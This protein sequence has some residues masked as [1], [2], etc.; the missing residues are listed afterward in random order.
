[1]NI[2]LRKL[3]WRFAQIVLFLIPRIADAQVVINEL[4]QD[5]RTNAFSNIADT[6]EFIEL[7]NTSGASVDLTGWTLNIIDLDGFDAPISAPLFGTIAANEPYYVIGN[8]AGLPAGV[9]DFDTGAPD[10][11]PNDNNLYELRN[12]LNELVDALGVQL[13]FDPQ[14]EFVTPQQ[15]AQI[16]GGGWSQIFTTIETPQS[17]GRFRD[18]EDTNKNGRDFGVIRST[19]GASNNLPET[20]VLALPDVDALGLA[21]GTTVPGFSYSFVGP[22]VV[23]PTVTGTHIRHAL[24]SRS[25]QGG[26]AIVAW[27]QTGGGNM[28][29]SN[30]LVTSFDIWAYIDTINTGVA[31]GAG[32]K[33]EATTYGIGTT[34]GSFGIPDPEGGLTSAA[35]TSNGNTGVGW[36]LV[37]EDAANVKKLFLIDFNDGGDSQPDANDWTILETIDLSAVASNWRRLSIDYDPETGEVIAR[38]DGQVFTHSITPNMVGTF[39][40]GFREPGASGVSNN[41]APPIFDFVEAEAIGDYNQD[42]TIDAA[43]YIVWRKNEGTT[44]MLPNDPIGGMIGEAQYNQWRAQ[45]GQSAGSRSSANAN[46]HVPEPVTLAMLFLCAAMGILKRLRIA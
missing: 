34:D 33:V 28:V 23:D 41:V 40:V 18:G 21:L 14:Y 27:D 19:P 1:M 42:G 38:F 5:N 15:L 39:Y 3:Q 8:S 30:S 16:G 44:N 32:V 36:V 7:Y 20:G 6:G 11:L 25:P 46:A 9:V 17:Y 31:G 12:P 4:V 10:Q 22:K 13:T 29:A 43:D 24:P 2:H 26:N 37:K 35:E 45:F